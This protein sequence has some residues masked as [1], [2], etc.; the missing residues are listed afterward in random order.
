MILVINTSGQEKFT[1]ALSEDDGNLISRKIFHSHFTQA[2]KL[3]PSIDNFLQ[4]KKSKL[5]DLSGVVVVKGPGGFTGL[6]IGVMTANTLAYA[7]KIPVVG[8]K[9]GD[10]R[11]IKDLAK[12]A[13][14]KLRK[15]RVGSMV[16]PFYGR[17]PNITKPKKKLL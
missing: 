7:L 16:I 8:F 6:R 14:Y 4:L 17:E 2:E 15:T 10:F 12:K 3:L 11:D 5:A 13:S 9:I 1:I